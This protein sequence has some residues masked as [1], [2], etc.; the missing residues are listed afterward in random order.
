MANP[1]PVLPDE[2]SRIVCP[3]CS[4]PSAS[5][6]STMARAMRS[7]TEPVGFWPSSLARMRTPGLGLRAESST[8][9]VLPTRSSTDRCTVTWRRLRS[10][11][12]DGREDG[13]DV[14]GT[15]GRVELVEVAN[16]VVVPV[17]VDELVHR[18]VVVDQLAVEERELAHEIVEDL[19]HG[20]A[21]GLHGRLASRVLTEHSRQTDLDFDRHGADATDGRVRRVPR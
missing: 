21:V 10:A 12:G 4:E 8:S 2:G 1:M 9:G 17:D 13:D 5:A 16:V 3:G 14:V 6:T 18:P 11:A 15:D 20:L 19:P 7:F